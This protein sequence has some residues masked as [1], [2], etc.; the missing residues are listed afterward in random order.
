MA[1]IG[2]NWRKMAKNGQNSARTMYIYG[3]SYLRFL[4]SVVYK[5]MYR[6]SLLVS[7]LDYSWLNKC[8]IL[9]E[10][11]LNLTRVIAA[12]NNQVCVNTA[13]L[14][15][16]IRYTLKVTIADRFTN[17]KLPFLCTATGAAVVPRKPLW[18]MKTLKALASLRIGEDNGG[19]HDY[20][21][22]G[23][24]TVHELT[25]PELT[26]TQL[27]IRMGIFWGASASEVHQLISTRGWRRAKLL[28]RVSGRLPIEFWF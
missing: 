5:C 11:T 28:P 21:C 4:I 8:N 10:F 3:Y 25:S 18:S 22:S 9:Y 12:S 24:L 2:Q 1:K 26:S 14:F 19:P 16:V 17:E 23:N 20:S 6:N 15:I 13:T 27:V 7:S